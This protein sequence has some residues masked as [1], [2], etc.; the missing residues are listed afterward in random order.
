VVAL[1]GQLPVLDLRDEE[2]IIRETEQAVGV[3]PDDVRVPALFFGE[4]LLR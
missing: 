4:L 1:D 2:Q 3:S